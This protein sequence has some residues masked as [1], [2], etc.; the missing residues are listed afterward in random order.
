MSNPIAS[1]KPAS[2]ASFAAPTAPAAGPETRI[3]AGCAAAW[4][5]VATPPDDRMT[6]GSGRPAALHASASAV[7][8]RPATGPRYASA[9]V[10]EA[11]SYSRNSGATSCEATTCASGSRR[12]ISAAT[13]R[14]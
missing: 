9:A 6:S 12:R 11:R 2:A 13:A 10:V 5:G 8:Y 1:A 7:R 4:R 3:V 14:S